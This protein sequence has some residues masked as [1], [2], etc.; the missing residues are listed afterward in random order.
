MRRVRSPATPMSD[1]G[2]SGGGGRRWEMGR[3]HLKPTH[4]HHPP[5]ATRP[6][7][8]PA[9]LPPP[10][11]ARWSWGSGSSGGVSCLLAIGLFWARARA[12]ARPGARAG[13]PGAWDMGPHGVR[14]VQTQSLLA[15]HLVLDQRPADVFVGIIWPRTRHIRSLVANGLG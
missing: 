10:P 6:C 5:P 9:H 1:E 14:A 3:A 7:A 12:R 8:A 13:T 11:V 15:H 4:H 2:G